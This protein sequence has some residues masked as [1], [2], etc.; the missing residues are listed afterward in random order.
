MNLFSRIGNFYLQAW[1]SSVATP[2]GRR[3]WLI[4]LVK[5]SVLLVL[6]KVL[7]FPDRLQSDYDSDSQR[8]EAVRRAL[9]DPGR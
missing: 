7:F 9:V 2:T 1:R 6:F 5:V 8:A 4:L 3:L